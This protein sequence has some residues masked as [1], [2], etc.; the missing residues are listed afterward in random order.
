MISYW[1]FINESSEDGELSTI[2]GTDVKYFIDEG[3]EKQMK[4]DYAMSGEDFAYLIMKDL[5][6]KSGEIIFEYRYFKVSGIN[7]DG[8]KIEIEQD[9]EYDKYGGPYDP[10]MKLPTFTINSIDVYP[11]L[12]DYH[13]KYYNLDKNNHVD[14]TRSDIFPMKDIIAFATDP[15]YKKSYSGIKKYDL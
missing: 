2:E 10:K 9:G 13:L 1:E 11:F 14:M 4:S 12:R 7:K 3:N 6:L 15:N 5:N 8:I